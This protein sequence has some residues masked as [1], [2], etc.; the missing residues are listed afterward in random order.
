MARAKLE[1]FDGS[2]ETRVLREIC[3]TINATNAI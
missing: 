1:G 3:W 2:F